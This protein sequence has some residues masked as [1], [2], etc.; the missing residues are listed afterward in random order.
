LK[1]KM[2]AAA[3]APPATTGAPNTQKTNE[4]EKNQRTR[5]QHSSSSVFQT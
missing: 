4:T 1:R 2:K 3:R 5:Q